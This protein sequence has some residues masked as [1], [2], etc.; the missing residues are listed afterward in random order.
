MLQPSLYDHRCHT[1]ITHLSITGRWIYALAISFCAGGYR[2]LFARLGVLLFAALAAVFASL[3]AADEP[4]TRVQIGF[5]KGSILTLLKARGTLDE[6]L[7]ARGIGARWLEFPA[8]PQMLE[9]LNLG[10]IDFATVGD[11]PPI[12]AQAAGADLVYVSRTPANPKTEVI[13]VPKDSPL[14]SVADLAGRAVALNKGSDVNYLL[15]KALAAAGLDYSRITPR[16]LKPADAR[17]AFQ[18]GA[19]DA[20]AIWDPYYAE[21]QVNA[22]ARL[23]TDATDLVS[24]YSF[25]LSS[26]DFAETHPEIVD[27]F[28][29]QIA[30]VSRWAEAH[31]DDAAQILSRA[32]ALP[33]SIWQ[34]AIA[35]THYGLAPVD[36]DVLAEQQTLADTFHDIGLIPREV[37]VSTT[38]WARSAESVAATR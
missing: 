26:R 15:V 31:P 16:Y 29:Q 36:D 23:L 13:V 38:R 6:A 33:V 22:G 11:A 4:P 24:H 3:A 37:D 10:N 1:A 17:A 34:R 12:F 28:N 20:W 9:A 32:T 2:R 19:V 35:R 30:A 27:L 5:Q 8:G 14:H 7:K 25:Y 18:Q 21:A